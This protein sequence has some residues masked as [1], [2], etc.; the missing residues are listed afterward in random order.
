MVSSEWKLAADKMKKYPHFDADISAKA[1]EALANDRKKVEHHEFYPFLLFVQ[2]WTRYAD[3][4]ETGERKQR[5]I[6]YAARTDA[7]IFARY[8]HELSQKYETELSKLGLSNS[9]LAYRRISA[10]TGG[11]MCN[12]HF[13][14]RAFD[15]VAAQGNCCAI[16]LD[17]SAFFESLDHNRLKDLW[18]RLLGVARLPDDHF[19]VF[20]AITSYAV[21]EKQAAY[22]RLGHFGKK[23]RPRD[24]KLIPAYLTPKSKVPIKLC[25]GKDFREKIAGGDG[26]K[27][28][29]AK[30]Y[31]P[32]GI[33]QGAPIS[34]L[35]AN[36]YL[37]DFDVVV[38]GLVASVGGKYFRYSDDILNIAPVDATSAGQIEK[39]V[40]M[41]IS[42][43]GPKLQ[44]KDK[45]SYIVEFINSGTQQIFSVVFDGQSSTEAE[46]RI[47]A[48]MLASKID[49][50][51]KEAKEK[52]AKAIK[53]SRK[54]LNG[55]EYLGFRYDGRKVYLRD[56][57]VSNFWRKVKRATHRHV[58]ACIRRHP[59]LDASGI[60]SRFDCNALIK[61]FGRV[62]DFG[63]HSADYRSW[64]FW[65][66]ARRAAEIFGAT[67]Q[68]ILRQLSRH[69]KQIQGLAN[70]EI[71]AAFS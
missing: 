46:K 51:T 61:N 71:D 18:C 35:L 16:T 4:G 11:G 67:G 43:F 17:I 57:T 26:R 41:L 29:I 36:M 52:I 39:Q 65:T 12:I 31:K 38:H 1:A 56:S 21:V 60:K 59:K 32:Y 40:R 5:P 68:P 62:E 33:P 15:E 20:K 53:N 14:K 50:S 44:I 24:G 23:V 42:N 70:R 19:Q 64:T 49:L 34:D 7:Y 45:K 55:L 13:A 22:E 27:S 54:T 25:T 37:L 10:P 28:L 30:N 6:R 2:G 48:E 3:K 69:R 47:V 9:V 66:Y 8:R 58:R 63:E